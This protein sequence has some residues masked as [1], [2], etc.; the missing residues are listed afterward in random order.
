MPCF[1][2]QV[3]TGK[4]TDAHSNTGL[5]SAPGRPEQQRRESKGRGKTSTFPSRTWPWSG[6][7][8]PLLDRACCCG[9]A[10]ADERPGAR[11]SPAGSHPPRPVATSRCSS[12]PSTAR[13]PS[14]LSLCPA[15]SEVPPT[16]KNKMRPWALAASES[17][18]QHV[19][20]GL[21]AG[22]RDRA[23]SK[24]LAVPGTSL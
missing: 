23:G 20:A 16:H 15:S 22:R 7:L 14:S 2:A 3:M 18:F 13:P 21:T 4:D 6:V 8:S 12:G 24:G 10:Y 11:S 17:R 5:I 1:T 9:R 19:V